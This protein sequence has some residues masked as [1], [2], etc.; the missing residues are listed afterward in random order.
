[1]T[2]GQQIVAMRQKIIAAYVKYGKIVNGIGR[3]CLSM[4]VL[5]YM[6]SVLGSA[7]LIQPF[8]LIGISLVIAFLPIKFMTPL[9]LLIGCIQILTVHMLLGIG[10]F[11]AFAVLYILFIRLYPEESAWI[12]AIITAFVVGVEYAVPILAALFGTVVGIIPILIGTII[13]FALGQVSIIIQSLALQEG[14]DKIIQT[15][16]T[17]ITNN[18]I[19]DINLLATLVIF[20][21]VFLVT[22]GIRKLGIDYAAYVAIAIGGVMN[23]LGFGLAS[24]FLGIQVNIWLVVGMTLLSTA[25]ALVAEFFSK[26]LHYGGAQHV[27]F[28]DEDNYYYVKIVPKV[29]VVQTETLEKVYTT[30]TSMN[31]TLEE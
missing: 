10:S 29:A 25:I 13:F 5:F 21:V 16:I 1:M 14:L 4:M 20:L 30:S 7:S 6:E 27:Q 3:F 19:I 17:V 2:A 22:W 31:N 11:L 23:L 28:E 18:I 9:V 24:L 26:C 8:L 12:L 15:L